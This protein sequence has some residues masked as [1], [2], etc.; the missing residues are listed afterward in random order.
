MDSNPAAEN[1]LN[2][3]DI[4]AFFITIETYKFINIW[5]ILN[6]CALFKS[7]KTLLNYLN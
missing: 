5:I 7:I 6:V 3:I 1:K 4:F 2:C